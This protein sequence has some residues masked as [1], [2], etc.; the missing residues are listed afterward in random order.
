MR[1]TK[2][3]NRGLRPRTLA[4]KYASHQYETKSVRLTALEYSHEFYSSLLVYPLDIVTHH[5][6]DH[7]A[8]LYYQR[9]TIYVVL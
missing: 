5:L 1:R 3:A 4:R 2:C 6:K 9:W 8:S 7:D